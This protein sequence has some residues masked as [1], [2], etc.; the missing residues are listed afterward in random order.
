MTGA[1]G[2]ITLIARDPGYYLIV[3]R[4]RVPEGEE[5]VY[6]ERSFTVTLWFMVTK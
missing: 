4:H 3:V 1:N 6:D 2:E 5:G